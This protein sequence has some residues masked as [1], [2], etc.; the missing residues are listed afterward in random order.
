M[1]SWLDFEPPTVL[2]SEA[3]DSV[4]KGMKVTSTIE[5]TIKWVS[6]VMRRAFMIRSG[7]LN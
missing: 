7:L 6:S 4:L 5:V 1:H 3:T 2:Q